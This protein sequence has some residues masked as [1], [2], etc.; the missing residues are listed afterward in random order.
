MYKIRLL[1]VILLF[2]L[3]V[4]SQQSTEEKTDTSKRKIDFVFSIGG[5]IVRYMG[6]IQD[7]SKKVNVNLMGNR[8]ALDVNVGLS[9]SR[10][11]TLNINGV[12]GKISGNENTFKQHRNF[13]AEMVLAGVNVEYNFAG[14]WKKRTPILSPFITAGA[15]YGNYFNINTDLH[16]GNGNEYF[17][18]SDGKIRE[19]EETEV[20]RDL[21]LPPISRDYEYETSLVNKPVHTF[22]AS[23]GLGLDLHISRA[24]SVRLM[25][26]YFFSI[27]DKIDGHFTGDAEGMS[28][29][30]FINQLSLVINTMAFSTKRRKEETDY[31]YLFDPTQLAVVE[32]EDT[33]GDG[34]KDLADLCAATPAY[35]KVDMN[36]C[37]LDSDVDGIPDYRDLQK[38]SGL[39]AIVDRNGV[40][41]D[42]KV[43]EE[44][45]KDTLGVNRIRWKKEYVTGDPIPNEGFTVNI[46][47]LKTGS[48]RLLNPLVGGIQEL[49]KKVINDSLILF[50]LGVYD[51]FEDAELRSQEISQ[52]GAKQSYGV[53]ESESTRVAEEL[54]RLMDN[55]DPALK[56]KEYAI[57][58]NLDEIKGSKAYKNVT[59]GYTVGRLERLLDNDVPEYLLVQDFLNGTAPFI[60]DSIVNKSYNEVQSNLEKFP[61]TAKPEYIASES[62]TK[63]VTD[64]PINAFVTDTLE[65]GSKSS[66]SETEADVFQN[67]SSRPDASDDKKATEQ[68][69]TLPERN[70]A[71]KIFIAPVKPMFKEGDLDGNGFISSTEIERTLQEILEGR[72]SVTVSEFNEMVQYYTYYTSNAD[73]IDFGGTE[74]VILDGVLTILKKEGEGFPEESRRIL[75]K[76]YKEVDFDNDGD[77]TPDEVQKMI[78][79]FMEGDSTYSS[80]RIYELID[81]YFD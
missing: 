9:L 12:Y 40:S 33:D 75:A 74:V 60:S 56:N 1:G 79:M 21:N 36:G 50:T 67:E 38:S 5:G 73:P 6:D 24:L 14:A 70:L 11:F 44:L 22:A 76:K 80:E 23:A 81:L 31:K 30:F 4:F 59:L 8:P 39:D 27:S 49:R 57:R 19:L 29:G 45:W 20:N 41:V 63:Q 58:K 37:P 51:H 43:L 72:S 10:S 52:L 17:Y 62:S 53:I 13:E 61:V 34:V 42:Y 69:M 7:G 68:L 3:Q 48:E 71:K 77:L 28:D 78:N 54:Y 16:D 46:K 18:W 65:V 25:S 2:S 66:N 64:E 15:Y 55:L 35:V 26:R 32:N 47:T